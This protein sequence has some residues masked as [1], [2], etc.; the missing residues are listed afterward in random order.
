MEYPH[1]QSVFSVT[2]S[3]PHEISGNQP[4]WI[5][6]GWSTNEKVPAELFEAAAL[7]PPN[8]ILTPLY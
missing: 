7:P 2:P 1:L 4:G 8:G 3:N 5:S 6:L